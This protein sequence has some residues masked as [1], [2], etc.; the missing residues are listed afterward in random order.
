MAVSC[1]LW[2]T[3]LFVAQA[4]FND[5]VQGASTS[6]Q[7]T[8]SQAIRAEHCSGSGEKKLTGS[9]GLLNQAPQPQVPYFGG[10]KEL[11]RSVVVL[12]QAPQPQAPIQVQPDGGQ[13]YNE[14]DSGATAS[15]GSPGQAMSQQA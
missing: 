6:L 7:V 8:T 4:Y 12:N 2:K 11:S 15:S 14:G 5:A 10:F 9:D 1:L 13:G 3:L